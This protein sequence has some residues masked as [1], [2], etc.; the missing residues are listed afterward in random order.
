MD[1]IYIGMSG[2]VARQQQLESIADNLANAQSP[3]FKAA[4]PAFESFLAKGAQGAHE[5][6]AAAVK[7]GIDLRPGPMQQ[8]GAPL[9]ATP[10]DGAFFAVRLPS[11]ATAFT[12][13]GRLSLGNDGL[14]H[15]AGG[16]LLSR[17]GA[18]IAIPPDARPELDA[19]G[20]V[21]A[22]GLELE[23]IGTFTVQG[24]VDRVGT[25]LLAPD[26][27]GRA[28]PAMARLRLGELELGNAPPLEAAV[29]MV[30]AQRHFET[31]M[32]AIETYKKLGDRQNQLG[33]VR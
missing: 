12:R 22:G 24:G 25:G 23:H 33:L 13:D 2:A 3:G 16:V 26:K 31:S 4:R 11:G 18:P 15:A 1:G 10:D 21:R 8:T 6:F 30:S 28:S 7:S 29:Q 19:T 5:Q 14:L 20:M 32:Q 9:D 27:S 17:S